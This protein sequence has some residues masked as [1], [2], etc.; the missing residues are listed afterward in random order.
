MNSNYT[1]RPT[2]SLYKIAKLI[3]KTDLAIIQGGQGAGKTVA[4][5]MLLIDLA[6]RKKKEI[7]IVS[8]ELSK[9]KG[10]AIL[11]MLK[12]LKDWNLYSDKQ[13]NKSDYIY[14]FDNGSFIEFIG[15]DKK[16]IG[17]GRRRD[18]VFINEAN[19][20]T[21]H[22]YADITARAK[23]VI[24]DYN[25]DSRFFLHDLQ[26]QDNFINLTYLD[27]EFLSEKE[28][29]NILKYKERG[30]NEDGTIKSEFWANKWRVF[31]LGEIGS[32]EGRIYYWNKIDYTDYLKINSPTYYGVDWG[33]VDPF[34]VVECKYVDGTLYVNEINYE[35]ENQIRQR[36]NSTQIAQINSSEEDGLI[37]YMFRQFKIPYD[38]SIVCDNNRPNKILSL[39]NAGWEGAYGIGAKSKLLDRINTNQQI[40]IVFTNTSK[41]IDHEQMNYKYATDKFGNKLEKPEDKDN[42]TID[43]ISY[44]IQS[45]FNNGVIKVI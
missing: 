5:L 30:Y 25:P 22:N 17:K 34:A 1:Y 42:H 12:I 10:T 38:A 43:A 29:N 18:Y 40:N 37:S 13:W 35:S 26:T 44:V 45:L 4:I 21:I 11:D 15:L 16:D 19:K 27:N 7:T 14:R 28:I 20:I 8:A 3:K 9:L 23:K 2:T 36:L 33:A 6:I 39:R 31:G 41:N 32:V 24:C